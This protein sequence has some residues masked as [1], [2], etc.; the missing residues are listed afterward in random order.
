MGG[1]GQKPMKINSISLSSSLVGL[2]PRG[3]QLNEMYLELNVF[4]SI[5][6][7][8]RLLMPEFL[9]LADQT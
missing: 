7:S 8:S 3:A 4:P 6:R 9:T 1:F 2:S 5:Y